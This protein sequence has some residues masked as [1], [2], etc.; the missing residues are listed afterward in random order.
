MPAS[1]PAFCFY[2]VARFLTPDATKSARRM[3]FDCEGAQAKK[4]PFGCRTIE[5]F[6]PG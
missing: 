5:E 6:L 3:S 1:R 2:E 4:A